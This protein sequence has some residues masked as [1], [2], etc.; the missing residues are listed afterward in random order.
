[1]VP[2]N[3]PAPRHGYFGANIVGLVRSFVVERRLGRVMSN[4]SGVVT[5]D[6]PDTVRGGDVLF[7]SFARLPPGPMPEGYLDLV[8]E[9]VFEVRSPSDRWRDVLAKVLEYLDAGISAVCVLDPGP[10]FAHV[11]SADHPTRVFGPADELAI[12]EVLGDFRAP[13][14]QFFE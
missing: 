1:V 6:D 9:L 3:V 14:R 4:D 10:Q 7:F 11:Y 2:V 8:P 13:V 5:E 12:S